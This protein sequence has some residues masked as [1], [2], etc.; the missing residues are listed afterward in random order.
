MKTHSSHAAAA[1]EA[2]LGGRVP[3]AASTHRRGPD[4]KTARP[5]TGGVSA[6]DLPAQRLARNPIDGSPRQRS[7]AQ[8]LEGLVGSAPAQRQVLEDE[9]PLQGRFAPAQRQGLED[10]EPLQ[11]RFE[12]GAAVQR[13]EAQENRTG[14]PDDLKAGVERLSGMDV[15]DVRVHKG[16]SKPAEVNALAYAQ[17]TD[18]HVAPGQDQHVAHEAWHV[19]Q[20]MQGRVRP[21]TEVGGVPVNDDP[22]L[23]R[24]ADVMGRKAL[25]DRA[26][27]A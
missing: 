20:Q 10:E 25:S 1:R 9:E 12:G 3:A 4:R 24:E 27:G 11:G 13:T 6:V 22:S 5:V 15:S 26:G 7:Q 18:I 8:R 16:S 2:E 17:G 21:T 14:L 19:V 23:E